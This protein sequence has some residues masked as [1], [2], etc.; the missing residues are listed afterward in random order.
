[1]TMEDKQLFEVMRKELYTPVVGDILDTLGYV[2]QFLPQPIGPIK[3]GMIVSGRAMP[4][5]MIDVYG[6]QKKPFGYLTEAL[7]QIQED[8]VYLCSG[9]EMRCAYWGGTADC[10][11]PYQKGCGRSREWLSSGYSPGAQPE[12]PRIQSRMLRSGFLCAHT[13]RRLPLPHRSWTG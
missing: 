6:V 5:L 12:F 8:E 13:G 4:V 7:D 2:H 1:M 11:H 3:E 10:Y 9:G